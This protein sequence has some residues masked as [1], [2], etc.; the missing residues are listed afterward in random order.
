MD[1]MNCLA[2]NVLDRVS[3]WLGVEDIGQESSS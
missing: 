1:A 3:E 2:A